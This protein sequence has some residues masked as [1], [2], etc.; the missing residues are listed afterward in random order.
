MKPSVVLLQKIWKMR[1]EEAYGCW[2][3]GRSMIVTRSSAPTCTAALIFLFQHFNLSKGVAV[4][5]GAYQLLR[6]LRAK[7]QKH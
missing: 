2:E 4:D 6:I 7:C 5:Y 3:S 1:F